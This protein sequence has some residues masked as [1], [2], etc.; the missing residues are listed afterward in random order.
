MSGK[1]LSGLS[2]VEL[3]MLRYSLF[4]VVDGFEW[5]QGLWTRLMWYGLLVVAVVG[6]GVWAFQERQRAAE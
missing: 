4:N 5:M 6:S 3:S 1:G 2:S